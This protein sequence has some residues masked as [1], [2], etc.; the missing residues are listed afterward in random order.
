MLVQNNA[1]S[2]VGQCVVQY[3]KK[4]GITTVNILR[5][6]SDWDAISNHL[7]GLGAGT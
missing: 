7:Q 6:R 2:T 3:A 4:R 5:H 1:A